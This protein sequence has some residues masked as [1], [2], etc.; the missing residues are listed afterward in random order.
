M[1]RPGEPVEHYPRRRWLPLLK[2]KRCRCGKELPCCVARI[3][4]RLP[5]FHPSAQPAWNAPTATT[6][7]LLTP[8]QAHRSQ[9]ARY[10]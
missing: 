10:R 2:P 5:H 7:P 8:G 9:Q 1:R 4:D 3:L 6:R